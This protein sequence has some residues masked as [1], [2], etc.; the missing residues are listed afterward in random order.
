MR[1]KACHQ[2]EMEDLLERCGRP[3]KGEAVSTLD[4]LM[5]RHLPFAKR[6]NPDLLSDE[7]FLESLSEFEN[8][9]KKF[10][11]KF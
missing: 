11:E 4:T 5:E 6:K 8:K 10:L 9:S 3:G 7:A 1:G 2:I